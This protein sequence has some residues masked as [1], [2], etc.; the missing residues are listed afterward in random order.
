MKVNFK[1][2]IVHYKKLVERKKIMENSLR[3]HGMSYYFESDYDRTCLK[4][5]D[6]N[7]FSNKLED[8]YKANFLSHIKCYEL[9]CESG[10]EYALILEDDSVPDKLFYENIHQYLRQLP[11]DFG[12]FF[13]SEGK[14]QLNIPRYLRRPF[15]KVYRKN[16]QAVSWGGDGASRNADAY[17]IS[18]KYAQIFYDEFNKENS[19]VDMNIDWWMNGIIRDHEIPVYWAQPFIIQTNKYETSF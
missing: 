6:K 7:K 1:I 17:F 2:Y 13:I 4:P 18:K 19:T 3:S 5:T 11:K 8:A 16:I 9:L 15:K 12:L 10:D 14:D